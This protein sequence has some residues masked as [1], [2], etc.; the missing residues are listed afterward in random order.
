MLSKTE[1]ILREFARMEYGTG[2]D[3]TVHY[4]LDFLYNERKLEP[5]EIL[6]AIFVKTGKRLSKNSINYFLRKYRI[7]RR[8]WR[9]RPKLIEKL[10]KELGFGSA[11]EYFLCR[12]DRTFSE[13][14]DELDLSQPTV[15]RA[16]RDFIL[17][18]DDYV[19]WH[20]DYEN[21]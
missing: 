6:R 21:G 20:R 2:T 14:A 3:E 10:T 5:H 18:G 17:Q 4:A 15:Q 13:M 12:A 1:K 16:Y 9:Q 11:A 8:E 7:S 19:Q